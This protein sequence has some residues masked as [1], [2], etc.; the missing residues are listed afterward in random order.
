[1]GNIRHFDLKWTCL[2]DEFRWVEYAQY[3]CLDVIAEG[4]DLRML[5]EYWCGTL[6]AAIERDEF[7]LFHNCCKYNAP[8]RQ[9]KTLIIFLR[10]YLHLCLYV[11]LGL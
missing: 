4:F 9:P 11:N 5:C 10:L 3:C 8:K 7:M 1:M 6:K 2:I